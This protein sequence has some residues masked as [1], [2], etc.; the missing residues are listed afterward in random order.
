M[1]I[2]KYPIGKMP[3]DYEISAPI[4]KLLGVHLDTIG[5]PCLYAVVEPDAEHK[6]EDDVII[7]VFW[8]G[9]EL[10]FLAPY[11]CY[12]STLQIGKLVYHYFVSNRVTP[13]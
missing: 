9:Q 1:K 8:T 6:A 2:Y 5:Q 7:H 10:P 11:W 3:G 4:V 12:L 13:V